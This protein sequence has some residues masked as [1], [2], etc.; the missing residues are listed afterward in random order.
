M[1]D[2]AN[3]KAYFIC[4]N[5]HRRRPAR[6]DTPLTRNDWCRVS[7]YIHLTSTKSTIKKGSP[8]EVVVMWLS[9]GCQMAVM[10]KSSPNGPCHVQVH[11]PLTTSLTTT[12]SQ[13]N[14]APLRFSADCNLML[15]LLRVFANCVSG[16]RCA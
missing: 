5:S 8:I 4:L 2:H 14:V 1:F 6:S 9:G 16:A 15:A 11:I 13:V 12:L 10:Q 7:R 3:L